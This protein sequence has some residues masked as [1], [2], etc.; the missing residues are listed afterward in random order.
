[1]SCTDD[2]VRVVRL[3]EDGKKAEPDELVPTD[4]QTQGEV[5]I[6]SPAKTTYSYFK[7]D[8]LVK[9]KF[10]KGWMYTGDT[11]TW[12]KDWIVTI[13]GRKDDMMVVAGENIYPTQIEE[14][15]LQFE[16]VKDCIVTC[17][18]D[19]VRGQAVTAY[20]I[21]DDPSLT[22]KEL[23]DFCATSK[24]LSK[25]KRPRYFAIVDNI[26]LTA[27]GKKQHNKIKEQAAKDLANGILLRE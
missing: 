24:M 23:N 12:N 5:I 19:A 25:Y 2:E 6:H 7:N 27:T 21:A 26:P 13:K 18:P 11:G 20:V 22:I 14:A 17:V 3:T 4:S 9:E 15:L 1:M 8:D 10:Y 16:K